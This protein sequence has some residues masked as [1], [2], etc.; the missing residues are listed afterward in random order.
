MAPMHNADPAWLSFLP[1]RLRQRLAGR[2]AFLAALA[3]SGW[4]LVDRALRIL[5]ALLVG[6]W[7]ARHLGP[8]RYGELAYGVALLAFM[9]PVVTLGLE[10]IVVREVAQDPART[11]AMLGS[12]FILRLCA[13]AGGWLAILGLAALLRPHDTTALLMV[14]IL[15]A[16]LVLQ[17]SDVVDLWFQSQ[18]RSKLT[19]LSRAIAYT[20]ASLVK[21]VL[22]LLDAPL[23]A[24]AAALL[25]DTLLASIALSVSYRTAPSAQR[26]RWDASAARALLREGW[27]FMLAAVSVAVYMRVDQLLLRSL[28][29][30][31]QLGLYSAILP[32][33]QALHML[34]MT[35][36]TSLAPRMATLQREH[37][38]QYARRVLQL[39]TLMAWS[40]LAV[41]IATALCAPW[42][43][44]I[45][46]G[47][48]FAEAAPVLRW[49]ALTNVFVFLGVAQS[50]MIVNDRASHVSLI[51]TLSGAAVSVVLN[52]LL[53]PR[54]GAIGAAWAAVGSYFAAAILTNVFVAPSALSMQ[55]KAFWPFHAQRA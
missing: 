16:G 13:G 38:Q 19:V 7:V 17:S 33:S 11:G 20:T 35:V 37:P 29:D 40:G 14:G 28:T 41:S 31:R 36:C 6:A 48:G 46:L 39:F 52:L 21:V 15:G 30:E 49:H 51:K 45:L 24:F 53:V 12:A 4:L 22:I 55:L 27:P 2:H 54:W 8:G 3:N 34:P 26:W 32:L 1:A 50:I 18:T 10:A 44:S 43:V 23:W 47:A 42:L 25:A 9:Q 5:L